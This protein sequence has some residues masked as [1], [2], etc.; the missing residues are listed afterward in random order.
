[1]DS[2]GRAAG[3][4]AQAAGPGHC[5]PWGAGGHAAVERH[6][7]VDSALVPRPTKTPA[8][9]SVWGRPSPSPAWWRACWNCCARARR[10]LGRVLDIGTGC[11]YQ[12]AVLSHLASEVYSIERLRALHEKARDNL[13]AFGWPMCTCC[14]ATACPGTRKVRPMRASLPRRAGTIA[15]G[16]DRTA[17]GGRASGGA[18]GDRLGPAAP[19][20]DRA[21]GSRIHTFC[22]GAGALRA[23]KIRRFVKPFGRHLV[24]QCFVEAAPGWTRA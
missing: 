18:G 15:A 20:G 3:H 13:R 24:V 21:P 10:P 7:F 9:R 1:M 14:S 12:A 19:G 23:P 11:G 6:R 22:I 16:L 4:G 2:S 17:G 5:P 8:C